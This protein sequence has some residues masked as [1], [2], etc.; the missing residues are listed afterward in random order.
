[1]PMFSLA[2]VVDRGLLHPLI[3]ETIATP[4]AAEMDDAKM[5]SAFKKAAARATIK[6]KFDGLAGAIVKFKNPLDLATGIINAKHTALGGPSGFLG[7]ATTPVTV[8]PD[9]KGY[10]RHF[11]GGSIYWHYLSGAHEVHG[12]IRAKWAGLGWEKSFLGYPTTDE[13]TGRDLEGRGRFNHFQGGSIYWHPITAAHEVHG[14]IRVKYLELGAEASFLGYPT[15]DETGTPDGIG[16]FNHFQAGSIYWTAYTWAHEVHGL[17]RQ[18]W[19]EHGWERNPSL[20]YPISD[21]L[22]P[23]RAIGHLRPQIFRKPIAGLPLDV[24]KLPEEATTPGMV[25]RPIT[26]VTAA[27][28]PMLAVR[29]AATPTATALTFRP[30]MMAAAARITPTA[31][32]GAPA[33]QPKS[34]TPSLVLR[35]EV[36][37]AVVSALQPGVSQA[38]KEGGVSRNRFGDFENGVLFWKRGAGAAVQLQPWLHTARGD[39]LH[40]TAAEVVAIAS[41]PIRNALNRVNGAQVAALNF[42]GVTRYWFDGATTHNRRHKIN[43]ILQGVRIS[44]IFPQPLAAT[45]EVHAEISYD[46]L[47]GRIVGYLTEWRLLSA[48]GDFPGGPIHRQ[49]HTLLDCAL[50][51]RFP[52]LSI[53]TQDG[54]VLPVLSVK[55]MPDGDVNVYIEP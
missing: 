21:E 49:L 42:A 12:L 33:P 7:A 20:G 19:A 6:S 8:C 1:M 32:P 11:K 22:I 16:R 9:S 26:A 18:L 31:A 15:T 50:W 2:D 10:Y 44:G 28:A 46:P 54:A 24:I 36:I 48:T 53:P 34:V 30:A 52:V 39:K 35:P 25:V 38:A 51:T 13:T 3:A 5:V 4:P 55:T 41:T 14:A 37:G 29:T 17:I 23:D 47:A 27:P 40:L 43:V 45:V